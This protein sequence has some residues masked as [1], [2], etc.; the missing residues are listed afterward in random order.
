MATSFASLGAAQEQ[1]LVRAQTATFLKARLEQMVEAGAVSRSALAALSAA[2]TPSATAFG[3]PTT[4]TTRRPEWAYKHVKSAVP[5]A[6][7]G[8]VGPGGES[9]GRGFRSGG[10]GKDRKSTRLNSSHLKLS[11]MP[12]SA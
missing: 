7:F 11:R 2:A 1:R 3:V 12:S 4:H 10:T 6:W 5:G 8:G 9:G